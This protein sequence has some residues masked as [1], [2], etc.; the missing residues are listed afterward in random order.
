MTSQVVG[1]PRMG[2]KREL[3][4]AL[5]SFWDGKSQAADLEQVA[6][7]LRASIW[8]QMAEAGVS[9]IPSNTFS[10]YDQ[11]LDTTALALTRKAVSE[12]KEAKVLGVGEASNPG[13]YTVVPVRTDS[14]TSTNPMRQSSVTPSGIWINDTLMISVFTLP[15]A[16]YS[17]LSAKPSSQSSGS[18]G[19][20]LHMD[21]ATTSSGGRMACNPR[22]ITVFAVPRLPAMAIPPMHWSTAPSSNADLIASCPTTDASGKNCRPN[23]CCGGAGFSSP[24]STRT[25]PLLP[26]TSTADAALHCN[27]DDDDARRWRLTLTLSTTIGAPEREFLLLNVPHNGPRDDEAA[28]SRSTRGAGVARNDEDARNAMASLPLPSAPRELGVDCRITP[29]TPCLAFPSRAGR[30]GLWP[31]GNLLSPSTN[32]SERS[33]PRRPVR[34]R[35]VSQGRRSREVWGTSAGERRWERSAHLSFSTLVLATCRIL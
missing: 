26:A 32:G 3:K 14:S 33:A 25:P 22:A 11:V 29:S 35:A 24:P 9:L 16:L 21:P 15:S 31:E 30:A 12:Y 7:E 10:Y 2:P 8:K 23:S 17:T 19:S 4:F 6:K 34:L 13:W 27:D 28:A 1:Y 18:F 20:A 5:E